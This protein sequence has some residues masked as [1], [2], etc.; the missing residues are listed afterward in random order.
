MFTKL[1]LDIIYIHIIPYIRAS[2]DIPNL[3]EALK[4]VDGIDEKEI[5]KHCTY[6]NPH[7]MS[8]A[9]ESYNYISTGY[10][11]TCNVA[12][13]GLEYKFIRHHDN[14]RNVIEVKKYIKSKFTSIN[15]MD[16]NNIT[17]LLHKSNIF[18]YIHFPYSDEVECFL[19]INSNE[20]LIVDPYD[21]EE[22]TTFYNITPT[23]SENLINDITNTNDSIRM[24]A[25][26]SIKK[27]INRKWVK[28]IKRSREFNIHYKNKVLLFGKK[29]VRLI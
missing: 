15:N 2:I 16:V 25:A 1:P 24:K 10:K 5:M 27:I 29:D 18:K 11:L 13:D 7:G 22:I 4:N 20:L 17:Y 28:N 8:Y 21:Y 19:Y 3:I 26:V 6:I 9:Y 23:S 12:Y 14:M